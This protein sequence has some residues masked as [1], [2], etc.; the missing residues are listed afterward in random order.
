MPTFGFGALSEFWGR[1]SAKRQRNRPA[2]RGADPVR[3][4]RRQVSGDGLYQIGSTLNR[5]NPAKAGFVC[6]PRG[7]LN[8]AIVRICFAI[9]TYSSMR[10]N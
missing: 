4:R 1:D 10:I 8:D 9:H 3:Q 2:E 6:R 5:T 7:S